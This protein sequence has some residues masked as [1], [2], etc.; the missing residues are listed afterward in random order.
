MW[1]WCWAPSPGF[2]PCRE[3]TEGARP[4]A[5]VT[6][7]PPSPWAAAPRSTAVPRGQRSRRG[8]RCSCPGTRASFCLCLSWKEPKCRPGRA[9][10]SL[11]R[12]GEGR[13]RSG[14]FLP[15]LVRSVGPAPQL[16]ALGNSRVQ[17]EKRQE[18][19]ARSTQLSAQKGLILQALFDV[20]HENGIHGFT[21]E[22]ILQ[23]TQEAMEKMVE[24]GAW[25]PNW[26]LQTLG[27]TIDAERT[28]QSYGGAGRQHGWLSPLFSS[29]KPPETLL[30]ADI[31]PGNCWAFR[32]SEGDVV[33]RLPQE[34]RPSAVTV[35]HIST[36]VSPSGEVSSAPREFIVLGMDEDKPPT[37]LG[38]FIYDIKG[39]IAQT[40]HVQRCFFLL[41]HS[42][43][44]APPAS[45]LP[46]LS[47]PTSIR[48]WE[49]HPQ[50][51]SLG[52]PSIAK[53]GG[54][55]PR[56]PQH[57]LCPPTPLHHHSGDGSNTPRLSVW[58]HHPAASLGASSII[59][60]GRIPRPPDPPS[61]TSAL[62]LLSTILREMG[63]TPP[64]CQFGG[65]IQQPVWGH[66]PSH[67][68]E[69]HQAPQP[70]APPTAPPLPS[71]SSPPSFRSWERP[72]RGGASCNTSN[73]T[74]WGKDD[75][76]SSPQTPPASPLPSRS[77]PPSVRRWERPRRADLGAS[78][79]SQRTT[80]AINGAFHAAL[81][82]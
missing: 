16:P 5:I 35:W 50:A 43:P 77:S 26:A 54:S 60:P 28:S 11:L 76:H 75:R 57:H 34:I 55:T 70:P 80:A 59:Q 3:L 78:P 64:G 23:S 33:I 47:P 69:A 52:A 82:Q 2:R 36:A 20:L 17:M 15:F 1:A 27:A 62:P 14:C 44:Q 13:L 6:S 65:T 12:R 8:E 53:P 29:A 22:E 79:D 61:T 66:H 9:G 4:P 45:P 7:E 39:E 67:S 38:Y 21:S 81:C 68:L 18:L 10:D 63:A 19:E 74:A 30:Q 49:Q 46:S 72:P 41:E 37:S 58:G 51:V 56:P 73:S 48:R 24:N 42:S 25:L 71:R 40:F 31:S 32:G